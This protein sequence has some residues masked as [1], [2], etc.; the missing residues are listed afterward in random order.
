[1]EGTGNIGGYFDVAQIVLYLFW[2]F[3]AGLIYY[4]HRENK[5]EGY[6]LDSDRSERS[7]GRVQV[8]GFPAPP[9]P[10]TYLLPHGGTFS[11]PNDRRDTRTIAARPVA[12]FPG[13]PLE[14]TGSNPMLD[15]VGPGAYAERADEPDLTYDGQLKIVPMRVDLEFT[16]I[17]SPDPRGRPVYGADGVQ[18]GTV[19]DLWVDRSECVLRYLEVQTADAHRVLLPATFSNVS[20]RGVQVDAIL[21]AQFAQVP[22]LRQA[23]R[24]TLLEEERI[25]AYYGAGTLYATAQRR[26]P[27]L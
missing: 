9:P 7:G 1:M 16:V 6:P 17:K 18:G 4:L 23:E 22:T 3:F 12:G 25:C 21:G 24:I 15:C 2:M 20:R 14:P 5:R 10:K 11:A 26:E 13:A 19:V 8:K 27:L